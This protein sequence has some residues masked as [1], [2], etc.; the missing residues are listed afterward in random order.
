MRTNAELRLGFYPTPEHLLPLIRTWFEP[1]AGPWT[2]FDPTAGAGVAL[3]AMGAPDSYAVELEQERAHAAASRLPHVMHAGFEDAEIS[4]GSF[5]LV[6]FNPPYNDDPR[7]GGRMERTFLTQVTPLLVPH[8]LLIAV[9]QER[10]AEALEGFIGQHYAVVTVGRFPAPDYGRFKQVIIL[11]TKRKPGLH[12]EVSA[13]IQSFKTDPELPADLPEEDAD[14][15]RR[16][17]HYRAYQQWYPVFTERPDTVDPIWLPNSR[18][19]KKFALRPLR[20]EVLYRS[21]GQQDGAFANLRRS[22][23][24]PAPISEEHPITTPLTLGQGHMATLLAAGL[25]QGA[26]GTGTARHLVRGRVRTIEDVSY[27][28]TGDE[29]NE[30]RRT[31][32]LVELYTLDPQGHLTQWGSADPTTTGKKGATPDDPAYTPVSA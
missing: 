25:L 18:G 32:H 16:Y 30:V 23:V 19:P 3:A 5:S 29:I 1:P 9:L 28:E 10:Q 6:F 2:A 11:A 8:G 17:P 20:A 24:P 4:T 15:V 14:W 22:T 21:L 31:Q 26:I 13:P 27:E 12:P 7:Q